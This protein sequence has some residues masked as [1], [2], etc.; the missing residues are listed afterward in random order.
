M[1]ESYLIENDVTIKLSCSKKNK[2][3]QIKAV[4]SVHVPSAMILNKLKSFGVNS[5]CKNVKLIQIC[6]VA[7]G[8]LISMQPEKEQMNGIT[9]LD[10]L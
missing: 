3:N 1:N 10:M 4:S 8:E 5:D 7:T 9:L 6:V 2:N